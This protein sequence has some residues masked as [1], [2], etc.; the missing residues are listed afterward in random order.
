[1]AE[2]TAIQVWSDY[3]CPFCYLALPALARAQDELGVALQWRA[4]ELR[5]EPQPTLDPDGEYL[6][7]V[8]NSAVYPMAEERGLVLRLPP[9]QPRSRLAAV[10]AA[11]A[12]SVGAFDAVHEALFRAFFEEGL[13]IGDRSVL[14]DIGTVCGLDSADLHR[15]LDDAALLDRVV[16]EEELAARLGIAGVPAMVIRHGA[17]QA[18]LLSGAQPFDVLAHAVERARAPGA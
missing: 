10:A 5:P 14:L 12:R 9:V 7:N 2:Q 1:M 8:W 17:G 4:F 18:N 16:A 6:H 3:V 13:D 15:A 11:Y